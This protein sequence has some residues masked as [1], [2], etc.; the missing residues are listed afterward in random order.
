MSS[1]AKPIPSPSVPPASAWPH[2]VPL[3]AA[4]IVVA[5]LAAYLN[6]FSGALVYDDR[7]SITENESIRQLW[8]PGP[9]FSPPGGAGTGGRPIANFTFAVSY[10]LSGL[11][12][13]GHHLVNVLTHTLAALVLFGV[14]RRTLLQPALRPRFGAPA[15]PLAGAIAGLWAVHPLHTQVVTYLSQRTESLMALF[16]LL[17]LYCFIRGAEARPRLWFPLAVVACLFGVMCKEIIATVPLLVLLY[18][19][20]FVAGSFAAALRLRWRLYA[21]LAATWLPLALLLVGVGERGVGFG[22]GIPWFHYALTECQAVLLYLRLALVPSPLVFDRGLGLVEDPA[23]AAPFALLLAALLG[24]T[25]WA[26]WRRPLLGFAGAWFFVILAPASSVIPVIQQP[27][28]ENRPYLPVAAVLAVAVL[29]LH[30]LAGRRAALGVCLALAVA[31][32]FATARRNRDYASEISLWA[33]TAAKAPHNARAHYNLGVPLDYAG[34][35]AEA[36]ACYTAAIAANPNYVEAHANLGN[37]LTESGRPAEAV[38]HLETAV[39]LRPTYEEAHYNLGNALLHLG[40][41]L[42]AI[43]RYQATLRLRPAQPK[44]RNNLGICFLNTGRPAEAVAEFRRALALQPGFPD[45][46]NNLAVA[47]VQLGRLPEAI[48]ECEEALRLNPGYV[49]ARNNLERLRAAARTGGTP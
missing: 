7:A 24:A 8:P 34:R 41:P 35:R 4:L 32:I 2:S 6:S 3:V 29:A 49:D 27:V 5:T 26:L 25:G 42:E 30:S 47:Y 38:P 39:R 22:L 14:V 11:A 45:P 44:A 36:M 21:A 16:Y 40:R 1:R 12:P 48:A 18:D 19:R 33:D 28:A 17:T 20:T 31:G 43:G 15:L 10:A 37:A 13:W 46:H 23:A 9:A